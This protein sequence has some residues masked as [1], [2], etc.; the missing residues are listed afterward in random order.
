MRP[1]S[2]NR[3]LDKNADVANVKLNTLT[4][5][6]DGSSELLLSPLSPVRPSRV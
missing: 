6:S 3:T 1:R 2:K 5:D 4:P